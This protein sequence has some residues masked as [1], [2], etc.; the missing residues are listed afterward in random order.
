MSRLKHQRQKRSTNCGTA[1]VAIVARIT[2]DRACRAMFGKA[3]RQDY[4]SDWIDIRRALKRL[5]IRFGRRVNR[6]ST[7]HKVPTTSF[8]ACRRRTKGTHLVV[9]S[10]AEVLFYDPQRTRPVT[11]N[12]TRRKPF[13]YLT[14]TPRRSRRCRLRA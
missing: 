12:R 13:S 10:P 11:Y 14:V 3:P 1:C 8:V 6:V 4:S 5:G 2:Q 7:W 9:C